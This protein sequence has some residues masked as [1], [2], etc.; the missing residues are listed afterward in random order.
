[1]QSREKYNL[2]LEKKVT[3]KVTIRLLKLCFAMSRHVE[4]CQVNSI[5]VLRNAELCY[6]RFNCVSK[7]A[8]W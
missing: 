5:K 6:N 1:M 2:Q 8:Y 4:P 3:E 7:K